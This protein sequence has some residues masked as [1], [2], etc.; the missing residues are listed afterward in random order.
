MVFLIL[1][2]RFDDLPSQV[3]LLLAHY[4]MGANMLSAENGFASASA[5]DFRQ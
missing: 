1:L 4:L 2:N 5:E 3:R